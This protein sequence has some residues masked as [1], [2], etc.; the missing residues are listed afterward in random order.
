MSFATAVKKRVRKKEE[1]VP[2]ARMGPVVAG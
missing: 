2:S 1:L